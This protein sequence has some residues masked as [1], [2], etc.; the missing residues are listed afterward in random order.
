MR[1]RRTVAVVGILAL[2]G[3]GLVALR[4]RATTCPPI[5]FGRHDKRPGKI[6][7]ISSRDIGDHLS[8]STVRAVARESALRHFPRHVS[9]WTIVHHTDCQCRT[10]SRVIGG[11]G[12]RFTFNAT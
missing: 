11:R 2:V 6:Y 12:V 1:R 5:S 8:C 3:L 4:G 10:A 7:G 9:G